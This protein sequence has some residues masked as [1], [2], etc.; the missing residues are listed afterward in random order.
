MCPGANSVLLCLGSA[1]NSFHSRAN[2]N[3]IFSKILNEK[4]KTK[5]EI[6]EVK[7]I[8][9]LQR[10]RFK[11]KLLTVSIVCL[12][13]VTWPLILVPVLRTYQVQL[14]IFCRKI[15]YFYFNKLFYYKEKPFFIIMTLWFGILYIN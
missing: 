6:N 4:Q 5:R 15:N 11:G 2:K 13:L 1:F 14:D 3:K 8:A 10:E 7:Q 12:M 9:N